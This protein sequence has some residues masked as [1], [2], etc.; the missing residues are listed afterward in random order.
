MSGDSGRRLIII[1]LLA[2]L[3]AIIS[4]ARGYFEEQ[5]SKKLGRDAETGSPY[6]KK[7]CAFFSEKEQKVK[8]ALWS[9]QMLLL[10]FEGLIF[11]VLC[12]DIMD[13]IHEEPTFPA[14]FPD[15]LLNVL[16]FL[17]GG[18][19][20][21]FLYIVFIR[22]LFAAFGTSR[23]RK[24]K[25]YSSYKLIRF[26]YSLSLPFSC[27]VNSA[28]KV[29]VRMLG[30]GTEA[31]D[32]DVTQDEILTLVGMGEENGTIES[33]EKE[34]IENVLDF[35]DVT[36]GDL[37]THRTAMTAVP[38]DISDQDL[39][40]VIEETGYSRI[41]VYKDDIDDIVGILGTKSYLL[42]RLHKKEEQKRLE[43]LLYDPHFVPE[44]IHATNLLTD[45]KKNKVHM[46]VVVDEYGGTAGIITMEDL[47]EEIVGNI[48]DETDDP[49]DEE[50]GDIVKLEENLWRVKG[51][52]D[53]DTLCQVLGINLPEDLGVET[54]AGLLFSQLSVIPED[55]STPVVECYG[56]RIQ[57]E[58]IL[59]RR[60]ESALVSLLPPKEEKNEQ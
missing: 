59:E 32:E 58:K 43:E 20:F 42:N 39:L 52:A 45:M 44:S 6:A 29:F 14:S 9:T 25:N 21:A 19:V 53:L 51:S 4:Y 12:H 28:T 15:L 16:V 38:L 7:M 18:L 34:M 40:S 57:A 1:A 56:L 31:L 47:L 30:I 37:L 8:D 26:L 13:A 17:A 49:S 10:C 23:G 46:S 24:T 41:P 22:R 2:A 55:G 48:Y 50:E 35:T 27:L 5:N 33:G 11:G 60:M 54:L 36:A 3:S